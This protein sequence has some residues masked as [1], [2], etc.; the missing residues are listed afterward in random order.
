M[1]RIIELYVYPAAQNNNEDKK[2]Y[3]RDNNNVRR[4]IFVD[5]NEL[6]KEINYFEAYHRSGSKRNAIREGVRIG[7]PQLFLFSG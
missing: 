3:I 4:D 2:L 7:P 5:I 1:G 6:L